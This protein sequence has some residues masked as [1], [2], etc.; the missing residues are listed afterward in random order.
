MSQ[1]CK[2]D[3][4]KF[5]SLLEGRLSA[6]EEEA[7]RDHM[8]DCADC[9][10]RQLE[11]I[12]GRV[13]ETGELT[14]P[15][16]P[17]KKIEAQ[18]R[19]R[20]AHDK[21][22]QPTIAKKAII[23][24]RFAQ[25]AL[26]AGLVGLV[27]GSAF[28]GA[29]PEPYNVASLS[30]ETQNKGLELAAVVTL[31]QGKVQQ[32]SPD[33]SLI[34][35]DFN[36]PLVEGNR[37]VTGEEGGVALQWAADTG[38]RLYARSEVQLTKLTDRNQELKLWQGRIEAQI[39]KLPQGVTM[40]IV[41]N[42]IRATVKGTRYTVEAKDGR[43]TVEVHEGVVEVEATD[44]RWKVAVPKGHRVQVEASKE[45][46]ALEPLANTAA[47]PSMNL[48]PWQGL[49]RVMASTAT[50][51]VKTNPPGAYL[52]FNAAKVGRSNL[53][54][55]G[56]VG[57]HLVEVS[58]DDKFYQRRWVNLKSDGNPVAVALDV[59]PKVVR[60]RGRLQAGIYKTVKLRARG[61]RRCYER[62]LKQEPTLS[63]SFDLHFAIDESGKV[64][65]VRV[66]KDRLRDEAVT[67]CA[68][69]AVSRWKFPA[70][71]EAL[72]I[73]YPFVFRAN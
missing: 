23:P 52:K 65:S 38:V 47:L 34:G 2:A 64:Q 46:P 48:Q 66:T 44:G 45:L 5:L 58:R 55:R 24:W 8:R 30:S 60:R 31:L 50:L 36:R 69:R 63:G 71:G 7:L 9:G 13:R 3:L 26:A 35:V 29:R 18:I 16:L 28:F 25:V 49:H 1:T 41:S 22:K 10:Y 19:W 21:K 54:L 20:L 15:T 42:D 70:G 53:M 59:K 43:T 57:R 73:V 68:R 32:F 51:S 27:V 67:K 62:R 17:F 11:S 4:G 14:P 39:K 37:L 12:H 72:E 40:S 56:S 61:I 6:A 33:G